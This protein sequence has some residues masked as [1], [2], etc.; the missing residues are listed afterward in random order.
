MVTA[1]KIYEQVIEM[2]GFADDDSTKRK[3][4]NKMTF[5]LE[6]VA[7]RR[8]SEFK[9]GRDIVIPRN[10]APIIRNLLALAI[11]DGEEGNMI[12]DWFNGNIDTNDA[13]ECVL[14][15]MQLGEPIMRAEMMGETDS[16]TVDEWKA[17]IRGVL[18]YDMADRTLK[19][20][21]KLEEFRAKTL[22]MSN[23]VRNGDVIVGCEDGSRYYGME[24]EK[25]I[26]HLSE[27][28][29]HK[30]L[31]GLYLQEDYFDVLNQL[32]DRMMADA[33]SKAVPTIETYARCKELLECDRAIEMLS[34]KDDSI[35]S[36]YYPWFEKIHQFLL[37]HPEHV[38]RIEEM[39][40]TEG[41][42]DFFKM[43]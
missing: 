18:N 16:V 4:R 36:E 13:Q 19:M 15:Y 25:P 6:Q 17:S 24:S 5:L 35:V 27:E 37:K 10:D 3:L 33:E 8:V 12:V 7:L 39:A 29:I 22:V 26:K 38:T 11:D 43:K 23:T 42:T 30:I 31:D 32:M 14:L 9:Q 2:T 28:L 20:K 40:K 41:L 21:R 34:T 1:A